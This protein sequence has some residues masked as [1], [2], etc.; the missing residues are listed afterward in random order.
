M[1][2]PSSKIFEEKLNQV[3]RTIQKLKELREE[4][5]SQ[6]KSRLMDRIWKGY[7]LTREKAT[8]LRLLPGNLDMAIK[9]AAEVHNGVTRRS[10]LPYIS[11]PMSVLGILTAHGI[12]DR[13]IRVATVLHDVLEEKVIQ[14][15]KE[16][17]RK[18]QKLEVIDKKQIMIEEYEKIRKKFGKPVADLVLEVSKDPETGRFSLKTP[19]GIV[20]KMADR[21]HNLTYF[22]TLKRQK[23][24]VDKTDQ[25]LHDYE[26][27]NNKRLFSKTHR[28]LF[29]A[30]KRQLEA[31]RKEIDFAG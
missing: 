15:E 14:L 9:Y 30:L 22:E 2:K 31:R 23:E 29:T 21:Y 7:A 5:K 3:R 11:H 4:K 17:K 27:A 13:T 10:G 6:Y 28:S 24:Y 20:I 8:D 12:T 25:L 16:A 1:K 18:K 26:Y 19:G